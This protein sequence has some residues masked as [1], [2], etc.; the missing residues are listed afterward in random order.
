MKESTPINTLRTLAQKD[1]DEAAIRVGEVR[2][3]WQ[4]ADDQLNMLL[5]Y[6]NEYRHQLNTTMST[7]IASHRWTNYHQFI[8]TLEKAIDQHRQQLS[9]WNRRLEQALQHWRDKQQRLNAF[10][11]LHT[12]A[13]TAALLQE[14]RL[15]Q[16]LMDE[17]AQRATMRKSE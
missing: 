9:Q 2:R 10:E 12:R 11:T 15:D 8:Q 16:K 1:V 7:G 4:Q 17:Y 13:A 5:N 6:Q 3:A 14:S